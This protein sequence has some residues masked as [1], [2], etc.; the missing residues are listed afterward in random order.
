MRYFQLFRPVQTWQSLKK[1]RTAG[2]GAGY[3][4]GAGAAN[5]LGRDHGASGVSRKLQKKY[6]THV[7]YIGV[8]WEEQLTDIWQD[9]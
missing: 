5:A 6:S 8:Q 9:M 3:C 2:V 4:H 1:R 7:L